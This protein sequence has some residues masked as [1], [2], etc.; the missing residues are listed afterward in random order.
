MKTMGGG[1]VTTLMSNLKGLHGSFFSKIE[2]FEANDL[3]EGW[4]NKKISQISPFLFRLCPFVD[5]LLAVRSPGGAV[6]LTL[7]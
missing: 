3:E 6:A 7:L 1:H 5:R 2:G 4:K